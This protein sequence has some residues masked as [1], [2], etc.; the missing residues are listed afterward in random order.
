YPTYAR[1][2][3]VSNFAIERRNMLSRLGK[4]LKR[5]AASRSCVLRDAPFGVPQDEVKPLMALRRIFILRAC[6]EKKG[7]PSGIQLLFAFPA[8]AG[9]HSSANTCA[10][11]NRGALP[12][13]G[14][15]VRWSNGPR[16]PPGRRTDGL[17]TNSFTSSEE[18]RKRPS[19]RTR[20]RDQP[21]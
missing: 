12:I 16:L 3:T 4:N 21:I 5:R 15:P 19:R 6:E 2:K 9:I 11:S 1:L 18:A 20:G 14:E 10:S 8:K 17:R 13:N 7:E